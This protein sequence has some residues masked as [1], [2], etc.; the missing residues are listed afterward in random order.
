MGILTSFEDISKQKKVEKQLKELVSELQK[1]IASKDKFFSIIAH[2]LKS[3]FATMTSFINLMKQ[4]YDSLDKRKIF[5]MVKE[6][7]QSQKNSFELLQNLLSWSRMQ[8]G[9]M[10]YH[11]IDYD[12]YYVVEKLISMNQQKAEQKNIRINNTL[13][14]GLFIYSDSYMIQ[15]TL[16]N[17]VTNAIKFTAEKGKITL[18]A[19]DY[20]EDFYEIIV[21]DTG[22]GIPQK[23]INKLFKVETTYSTFGTKNEKGTGLGLVLCRDFVEKNGGEIWVT[24]EEGHG[25]SFHFTVMKFRKS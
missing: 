16:R 17:L 14:P 2:D 25:S 4:Y 22:I 20:D 23:D 3:P 21:E 10:K 12:L 11:P 6:L 24:S 9:L 13:Q 19:K 5:S 7:E 8:S 15:T 18:H 1:T